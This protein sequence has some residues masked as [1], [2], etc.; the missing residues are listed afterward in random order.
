MNPSSQESQR[1]RTE[2]L[3][4]LRKTTMESIAETEEQQSNIMFFL[5]YAPYKL[6]TF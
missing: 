1:D 5:S 6:A 2:T 3:S 4:L